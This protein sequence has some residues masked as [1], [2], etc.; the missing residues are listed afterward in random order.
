MIFRTIT[1]HPPLYAQIR[2]TACL[3]H[4]TKLECPWNLAFR[5]QEEKCQLECVT[6][7]PVQQHARPKALGALRALVRQDLRH[8]QAGLDRQRDVP[9]HRRVT[10]EQ[11]AVAEQE[12][13]DDEGARKIE[14]EVPVRPVR[15]PLPEVVWARLRMRRERC[16]LS[17]G[18][19]AVRQGDVQ[20]KNLHEDHEDGLEEERQREV[21]AKPEEDPVKAGV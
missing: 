1:K 20:E 7:Q 21:I 4:A 5:A 11:R 14:Q 6:D 12:V 8:R 2:I 18:R 17:S 3:E 10:R 13:E 16:V 9:E 19:R 15:A